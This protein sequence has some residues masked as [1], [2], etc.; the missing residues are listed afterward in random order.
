MKLAFTA[1][2]FGS[3][4][5]LGAA[6]AAARWPGGLLA[7]LLDFL[8]ALGLVLPSFVL[9]PLLI[10]LFAV[11]LGWLPS[12]ELH[13]VASYPLP[14]L[15]LSAGFAA[16]LGRFGRTLLLHE[17]G[18]DYYRAARARGLSETA[19]L[20]KHALP[21]AAIPLLTAMTLQVAALL[22][23]AILTEVIFRWPGIGELTVNAVQRHDL[24]LVAGIVMWGVLIYT[25]MVGLADF[26]ILA[27]DPVSRDA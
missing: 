23:G 27:I 2:L 20:V 3:L 15:A 11:V 10:W 16:Y 19:A 12:G 9:G 18:L 5:G 26:L 8:C 7:R 4:L 22:G 14:V 1:G 25:L 21:N 13:G 6:L 24:D 17:I